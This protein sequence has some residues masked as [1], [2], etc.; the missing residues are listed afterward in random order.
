MLDRRTL[1]I[2]DTS[3]DDFADALAFGVR[4][5]HE[6]IGEGAEE[7]AGAE[8]QNRFGEGSHRRETRGNS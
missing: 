8:L 2:G 4:L 7:P 5:L 3:D 1:P 6:Q